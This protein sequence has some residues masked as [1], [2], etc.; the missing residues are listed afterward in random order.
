MQ[1]N[2]ELM[3]K[4][5][6]ELK[7]SKEAQM[8]QPQ[9]AITFGGINKYWPQIV[10]AVALGLW[11]N[12]QGEKQAILVNRV[13]TVEEAVKSIGQVKAD[14][15]KSST[16]MLVLQTDMTAVKAAQKDQ[17]AKLDSVLSAVTT[18]GQQVQ[19]LSQ[20]MRSR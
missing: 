12:S 16:D 10:G 4:V 3:L 14:Q 7:S 5:L 11:L 15:Q 1:N 9:N 2:D 8:S 19:S 18:I 20:S 13:A 6:E 17:A